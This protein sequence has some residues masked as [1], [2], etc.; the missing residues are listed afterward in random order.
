LKDLLRKRKSIIH[1]NVPVSG[2]GV[3]GS[4]SGGDAVKIMF[5]IRIIYSRK[6]FLK[7]GKTKKIKFNVPVSGGGTE[8]GGSAIDA[9]KKCFQIKLRI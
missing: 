8:G 6:N 5:S 1:R 7:V 2:G 4:D 9:A 3:E